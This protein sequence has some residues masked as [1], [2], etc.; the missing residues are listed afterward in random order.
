MKY[1]TG[2]IRIFICLLLAF[3]CASG[4]TLLRVELGPGKEPLVER[5][6]TGEGENRILMVDISGVLSTG[7]TDRA[8]LPF[9]HREDPV[10][11]LAEILDHARR[12]QRIKGLLLRI[13]S[14]GGSVAASDIMYHQVQRY[15]QETG[16]R[17]VASMLGVAASG[18]YYVAMTADTIYALPVTIT[19]SIG[20]I[21]LKLNAAGFMEKVGVRTETIKSAE[22][23]DMGSPFRPMSEDEQRLFQELIDEMFD[24]FKSVVVKGRPKVTSEQL[25]QALTARVFSASQAKKLGLIDE[26]GYP[27]DAFEAAKKLAGLEKARLVMYQRTGEAHGNLYSSAAQPDFSISDLIPLS[28]TPELMYLWLPGMP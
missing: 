5:T 3:G 6:I 22:F 26:I 13:N 7:A 17:V 2:K 21:S 19:G 10:S 1:L 11:R 23:K 28:M 27:E 9:G 4:C 14:P 12:D 20:V 15:R 8:W 16:N 18:G 25:N 24:R